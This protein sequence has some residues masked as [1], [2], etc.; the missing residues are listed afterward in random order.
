MCELFS[1][2]L[3]SR[4]IPRKKKS[5]ESVVKWVGINGKSRSWRSDCKVM[6][7]IL[8]KLLILNKQFQSVFSEEQP[9]EESDNSDD[10]Y[11]YPTI[12]DLDITTAGIQKQ[13]ENLNPNKAMGPDQLHPRV[14]KN[15]AP[16][17]APILQVIFEKSLRE[18]EVPQ[19]WKKA[20]VA[21]IY[22]K[23]ERYCAANYR[24]VSLTCISSKLMEHIVTKH[25]I[26]FLET[27]NILYDLQYG[28]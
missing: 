28:F 5:N 22:K 9:I 17:V 18:G 24:P 19:D 7:Q 10:D 2:L 3:K 11:H 4:D 20:N 27:N 13:L 14:L 1:L 12:E 25:L 23:G 16:S 15:L 6:V 21:P 26:T 8:K